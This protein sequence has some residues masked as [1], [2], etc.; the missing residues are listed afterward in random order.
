MSR[1]GDPS[2]DLLFGLLALQNGLI[3]QD[4]LFAAFAAWTHDRARSLADHLVATRT[5][6][7]PAGPPSRPS[8]ACMSRPSA[9]TSRRASPSWPSNPRLASSSYAAAAP[10]SKRPSGTSHRLRPRPATTT[11]APAVTPSGRPRPTASGSASSV[12]TPAAAWAPSS[13]PSTPSCTARWRSRKSSTTTPTIPSAGPLPARGRGHRRAGA[14]GDRPGL[15]P[16]H[17]RRR[18]PLLRHAVHP[19]RLAQ[20]GDRP[21]PRATR[22]S[23]AEPG[24]RASRLATLSSAS[25]SADSWTS[26]TP[27]I[28]PTAA[29][30]CIATSSR[31]NIIVGKHGETLVVDWGLAKPLGQVRAGTRLGRAAARTAARPAAV[32]RRCR[33]ARWVRRPT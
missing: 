11:T 19:R 29:A 13:S 22:H 28:T 6:R 20:G 7:R 10:K 14:P 12:P 4:A 17:R 15:R 24:R 1:P 2:S 32:P 30:F 25:C 5:P 33:A 21:I 23:K 9:A 8:P 3:G 27:S 31:R 16:G 18:P 26:A